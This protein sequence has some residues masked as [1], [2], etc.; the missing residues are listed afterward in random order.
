MYYQEL[1]AQNVATLVKCLHRLCV[2]IRVVLGQSGKG[3]SLNLPASVKP[4]FNDLEK[5]IKPPGF[6]RL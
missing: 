6:I 5:Q 4:L 2:S 3:V 1:I